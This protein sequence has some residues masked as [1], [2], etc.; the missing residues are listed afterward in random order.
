MQFWKMAVAE[1]LKY[2]IDFWKLLEM[3]LINCK[4][5]LKLKWEKHSVSS[6]NPNDNGNDNANANDTVFPIK[7]TKLCVPVV[8]LSVRH[9]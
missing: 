3:S 6:A 5:E 7:D 8:S 4:V 1:L 9:Y 2:L